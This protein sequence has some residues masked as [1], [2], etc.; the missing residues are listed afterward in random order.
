[1]S[2]I[3]LNHVNVYYPVIGDHYL[4]LRRAILRL[5]SG[6]RLYRQDRDTQHVH[7]LK[8]ISL[9]IEKGDRVGLIGRNGAGKSTLLKTLGGFILPENGRLAIEGEVTMLADTQGGMDPERTGHENIFLVGR[10]RG[11][12]RKEM[13]R[14]VKEIEEF[15]ELGRFLG[16]PLRSYSDGMKVR[17]AIAIITCLQ[18]DILVLDEGIGAGDAHFIEKAAHRI[19]SLYMRANI[20]VIASHDPSIL[21]RLCNKV[22]WIDRGRILQ[23][24]AVDA[25]IDAY[26]ES[27]V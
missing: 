27:T 14:H 16:M 15:S 11:L 26:L 7:A 4:S 19:E 18:P 9:T 1:M 20:L 24:G 8:D 12:P 2:R 13:A 5:A 23:M 6:G 25:T 21:K 22:A 10:L 3:T 17:L